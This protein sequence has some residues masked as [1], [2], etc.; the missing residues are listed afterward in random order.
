M[1]K[2]LKSNIDTEVS[3]RKKYQKVGYLLAL[4]KKVIKSPLINNGSIKNETVILLK[5]LDN[6][7]Q[8]KI[9]YHILETKK[10]IKKRLN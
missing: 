6:L 2:Q 9:D 5:V 10:L 4:L 7:P 3:N 1:I 8:E